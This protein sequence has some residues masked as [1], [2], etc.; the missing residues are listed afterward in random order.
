MNLLSPSAERTV[1]N[2]DSF[3]AW[4]ASLRE[5]HKGMISVLDRAFKIIVSLRAHV[6]KQSPRLL[7]DCFVAAAVPVRNGGGGDDTKLIGEIYCSPKMVKTSR[8]R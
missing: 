4:L 6:A 8:K 7:G 1:A 3:Q 2:L 5:S